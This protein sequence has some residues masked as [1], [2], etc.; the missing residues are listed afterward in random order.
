MRCGFQR[1]GWLVFSLD[2]FQRLSSCVTPSPCV[3]PWTTRSRWVS[4][5]RAPV[6]S[7]TSGSLMTKTLYVRYVACTRVDTHCHYWET[8]CLKSVCLVSRSGLDLEFSALV[9]M[10]MLLVN[11]NISCCAVKKIIHIYIRYN[12]DMTVITHVPLMQTNWLH[13]MRH[14]RF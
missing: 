2:L 7:S 1:F 14:N 8:F 11:V 6:C 5:P 9:N 12:N 3:C 4:G 13:Y 10:R